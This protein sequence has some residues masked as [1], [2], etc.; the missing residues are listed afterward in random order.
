MPQTGVIHHDAAERLAALANN[1]YTLPAVALQILELVDRADTDT[2]VLRQCVEKDPAL[3]AK[4]LRVVNSSLYGPSQPI[5]DLGQA[6]AFLG[7][8]PLKLLVL[9]FSLPPRMFQGLEA[10]VLAY[11]WRHTLTKAVAARELSEELVRTSSEECFLAG[12]LQDIG[13][14]VFIQ[15]LGAPF[16]RF[17]EKVIE[18]QEDLYAREQEVFGFD[19]RAIS[20]RLLRHWGMPPLIVDIIDPS[21]LPGISL[22]ASL[23]QKRKILLAAEFA[24]KILGDERPEEWPKWENLTKQLRGSCGGP[25]AEELLK[26]IYHKVGQLAEVLSLRLPPGQ[27]YEKL[28][29]AAHDQLAKVS[30]EVAGLMLRREK[31]QGSSLAESTDHRSG[32]AEDLHRVLISCLESPS[33]MLSASLS[34]NPREPIMENHF[35]LGQSSVVRSNTDRARE[36]QDAFRTIQAATDDIAKLA[37]PGLLGHLRAT[38]AFC[39]A[40]RCGLSLLLADYHNPSD[41]VMMLG[42]EAFSKLQQFLLTACARLEHPDSLCWPYGDTGCAWILPDCERETAVLY[43]HQLIRTVG[44]WR[45]SGRVALSVGLGVG[46]AFVATPAPNF[47]AEDLLAAAQR[48]LFGSLASA[49]GVVKSIEI[50]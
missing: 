11:Y 22:G 18:K 15:C 28:L 24:A 46:I 14:L 44:G 39:R 6:L 45:I 38:V 42:E 9:G 13:L 25:N 3:A 47:P 41:L 32:E 19:H 23:V 10:K 4:I 16:Q 31:P 27:S 36:G 43:G 20:A 26:Q 5:G 8:K 12:L 50:Y 7:V 29:A 21:E 30:E 1:L 40:K 2:T 34:E 37:D 49:G 35:R 33:P 17:V 48:C